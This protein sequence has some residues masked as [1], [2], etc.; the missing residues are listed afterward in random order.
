MKI[1]L[2]NQCGSKY[3]ILYLKAKWRKL[4]KDKTGNWFCAIGDDSGTKRAYHSSNI[5]MVIKKMF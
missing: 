1:K 3:F 4:G 5:L 2:K